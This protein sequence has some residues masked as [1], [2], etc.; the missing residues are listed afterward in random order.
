ML[1]PRL[2]RISSGL[3]AMAALTLAPT[4]V[5]LSRKMAR[6]ASPAPLA[7]VPVRDDSP[8]IAYWLG[9]SLNS[10]PG[11]DSADPFVSDQTGS[12]LGM[13][14]RVARVSNTMT[15]LAV[16]YAPPTAGG[17]TGNPAVPLSPSILIGIG[18]MRDALSAYAAGD[19]A[20]GDAL[21]SQVADPLSR[22]ALEWA[23]LRG[24]REVGFA[25]L[26]A[27]LSAHPDWP[28]SDWIRR[29]AEEALWRDDRDPRFV[30]DFFMKQGPETAIGKLALARARLAQGR[31]GEAAALVREVW[32]D[33]DLYPWL[34]STVRKRFGDVLTRADDKYRAD[35][36]LYKGLT[37]AALRAAAMAGP[38][39]VALAKARA[40][41]MAG[42]ASDKLLNAVP[43]VLRQDPGY[44]FAKIEK[45]RRAGKIL[46]AAKEMLAAPHDPAALIDGDAWWLERRTI[47]RKLLDLGQA[48][49]A[50]EICAQASASSPARKIDAEFHA[51]WIA[52]RFLSEPA[53]AAGH[54]AAIAALARTPVS[55]ARAGYW[56]G[57]AAQAE[58]A[59]DATAFYRVAAAFPTTYYGQ[60]AQE[61]LGGTPVALEFPT[62]MAMGDQRDEAVRVVELLGSLG[63]R[64]AALTLAIAAAHKL[65]SEAQLAALAQVGVA[66]NDARETLDVGK[67]AERR[68]FP[69]DNAA[70]PTFGVPKFAPL[71]HSAP[72]D[73]VYA[74]ARQ[75]SAFQT[76]ALSSAGARGLMQMILSTARRTAQ[77]FRV[78]F[79]ASRLTSDP[80]FNAQLG[81]AHLGVLI[82]NQGGSLILT[83]AAYNA[84]E[85]R[86]RQWMK[87]YGDPRKPGVD[88]VDWV[89]RIP[90]TE[91]RN[92]VQ[93]V[94]EN[95]NVY[96]MRFAHAN[97]SSRAGA[98]SLA[99][100]P[101]P[102]VV[103]AAPV[104][105]ATDVPLSTPQA[106]L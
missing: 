66:L 93:R 32:R 8:D 35:R 85:T 19:L 45:L 72:P 34:E 11:P 60:L 21:A 9:P 52:L 88:P 100:T 84:G 106:R 7:L 97:S 29:R 82:H 20:Q 76:H 96:K 56:Q 102:G 92:Y 62:R 55:K 5:Q 49:M 83:F 51:G 69:L 2:L 23:A 47:A 95:F 25:R 53:V 98:H 78:P 27:F 54:F 86:V 46:A 68:G 79:D 91:T 14:A 44:F 99:A 48:K 104:A 89:E 101:G 73:I 10:A 77:Q 3:A 39:V 80:A 64:N 103:P 31:S 63:E 58:H 87:A 90:F 41:V 105:P 22:T 28:A 42:A 33:D 50:Y 81:A 16:A 24:P 75:E 40:A 37:R 12:V 43:T 57:R 26:V 6:L 17:Q 38:D 70:F 4:A 65:S 36:L 67:I 15:P 74:V 59:P 1:R 94:M 13:G 18:A 71:A 30:A 61:K